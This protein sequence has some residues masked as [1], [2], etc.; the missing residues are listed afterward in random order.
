M[1]HVV[2]FDGVCNLCQG[3]VQ[4]LIKLDKNNVL[5][6]SSLQSDLGQEI[7]KKN[8]L[9]TQ[10]FQSIIYLKD[11]K[12]YQKSDGIIE[13]L[14]DLGTGWNWVAIF[15][16]IPKFLRDR[17]YM[18]ISNNRYKLF[19]KQESCWLPTPELQKKFIS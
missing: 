9:D 17:I 19:G 6:F 2:F 12:I 13:I 7:L 3:S 5:K 4:Q 1:N 10:H 18:L 15:K 16:I 8:Q 14:L 11:D